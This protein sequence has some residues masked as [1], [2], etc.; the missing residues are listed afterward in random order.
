MV[1]E[2]ATR[3]VQLVSEEDENYDID[4]LPVCRVPEAWRNARKNGTLI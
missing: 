4:S 2:G 3:E 1:D